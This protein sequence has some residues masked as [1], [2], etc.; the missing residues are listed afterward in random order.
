MAFEGFPKGKLCR[1]RGTIPTDV[2]DC[3]QAHFVEGEPRYVFDAMLNV[4][5]VNTSAPTDE[6]I[7]NGAEPMLVISLVPGLM[8]P[9][10]DPNN[11]SQP[12]VVPGGNLRFR[13]DGEA[14][15]AIGQKMVEDG[16]RLPKRSRIEIASDL[17]GAEKAA[18]HMNSLRG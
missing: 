9:L 16:K 5:S 6:D 13:L 8:L 7:A 1:G 4:M 11:P 3:L 14:A 12:I 17:T 2:L 18:E 10:A 15:V